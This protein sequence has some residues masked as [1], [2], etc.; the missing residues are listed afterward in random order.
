MADN[1]GFW[2][3]KVEITLDLSLDSTNFQFYAFLL[4]FWRKKTS[5][6]ILLFFH[7]SYIPSQKITLSILRSEELQKESDQGVH[8]NIV[9][10]LLRYKNKKFSNFIPVHLID[11]NLL[12][13][14]LYCY[15]T[16]VGI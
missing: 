10:I 15:N 13:L 8:W 7:C 4:I 1:T 6:K 2:G 9:H 14:L 5:S 16:V 3:H 12:R 11:N